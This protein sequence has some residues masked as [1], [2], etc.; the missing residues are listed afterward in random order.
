MNKFFV[1]VALS[2]AL[3]IMVSP[4]SDA[5]PQF[6]QGGPQPAPGATKPLQAAPQ[7]GQANPQLAQAPQSLLV[8][9]ILL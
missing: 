1:T 8:S 5:S 6:A 7:P 9:H 3:A 2:M 4:L